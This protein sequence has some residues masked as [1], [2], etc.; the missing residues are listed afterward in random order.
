[1]ILYSPKIPFSSS[2]IWPEATNPSDSEQLRVLF[3]VII[4]RLEVSVRNKP[5][6]VVFEPP[7]RTRATHVHSYRI[8]II[9]I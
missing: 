5:R 6:V 7:T 9:A 3:D 1:M 4:L 2:K 8:R